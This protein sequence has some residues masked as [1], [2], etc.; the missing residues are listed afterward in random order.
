MDAELGI[1]HAAAGEAD[2]QSLAVDSAIGHCEKL[3]RVLE[4]EAWIREARDYPILARVAELWLAERERLL[5]E[6]E[7]S[8]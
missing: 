5:T 4:L 2:S 6:L 8:H 1:T 3:R 7:L